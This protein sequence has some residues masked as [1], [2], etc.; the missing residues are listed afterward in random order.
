MPATTPTVRR[1]RLGAEL[2][3]LRE[4]AGLTLEEAGEKLERDKSTISRIEKGASAVRAVDVRLMLEAYGVTDERTLETLM[5]LARSGRKRGWWHTYADLI[6]HAYSDL[7][8]LEE[9]ASAVRSFQMGVIPGL[10][11]TEDYARAVIEATQLPYAPD[12]IDALVEV[13]MARQ[14]I[15]T[16]DNPLEF[17]AILT[18]GVIRQR[19]GGPK[20]MH[21][22]LRHLEEVSR[23]PNVTLQVLPYD[24]GGHPG[25]MGS[26]VVLTFPEP[27]S[28]EVVLAE[29]LTNT[30]YVE[31]EAEVRQY[32]K[33]FD[34]LRALALSPAESRA[35]IQQVAKDL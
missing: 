30:L 2:R 18:E 1:R 12:K 8:S 5:A 25:L 3:R 19:V 22:Q 9:D 17:W 23:W 24:A 14:R 15:L 28:M 34:L 4:A 21:A 35:L 27:A 29:S 20:V 13:R 11:Q 26:F 32:T 10:L 31:E 6:S 7:I 33:G 16:R